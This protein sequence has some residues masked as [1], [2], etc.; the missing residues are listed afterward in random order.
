VRA[1]VYDR[2]GGPE[3]LRLE[4]VPEPAAGPGKVVV[5]V[6]ATS[7][8]LSDWEGL[9]GSPAYARLGGLRRPSRHVLG[10]DV[11]GVVASVGPGVTAFAEGDEV[12]GDNLD[13][14]GGFAELVVA[15]VTAL[16]PKP[17]GLSFVDASTLPQSGAIALQGTAGAGPGTRVLVNGAGGGTRRPRALTSPA[18]TTP[19]SSTS[20]GRPAPT[21]S[22]TSGPTTGPGE[23]RSTTSSTSWPTGRSSPTDGPSTRA[24]ATGASAARRAPWCG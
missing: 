5:R 13:L 19:G 14:M 7:V 20:C 1:V 10:S 21:R 2:Y 16:A 23:A 18:S 8:N 4:D 11:A 24:A 12:Y 15:P 9:R 22:S 3:V 17:A 6:V